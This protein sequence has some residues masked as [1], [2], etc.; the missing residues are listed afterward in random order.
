MRRSP[1]A[2]VPSL[3]HIALAQMEGEGLAP[4][5]RVELL[6][7]T[8]LVDATPAQLVAALCGRAHTDLLVLDGG[9]LGFA[10]SS[11]PAFSGVLLELFW[12]SV[13]PCSIVFTNW[14]FL[15]ADSAAPGAAATAVGRGGE[16]C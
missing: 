11:G 15:F 12:P 1:P 14:T 9:A 4:G 13:G 6:A 3:D 2:G 16:F 10:V 8:Q 5:V 7:V